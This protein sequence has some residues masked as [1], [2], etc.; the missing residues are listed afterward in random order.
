[1]KEEQSM[2][3]DKIRIEETAEAIR[4]IRT[5]KA[6]EKDGIE[7][8]MIKYFREQRVIWL[9]K[10]HKEAFQKADRIT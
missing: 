9:G 7:P 5:D 1:M 10:I 2:Q 4:Q 6:G 3:I 8:E